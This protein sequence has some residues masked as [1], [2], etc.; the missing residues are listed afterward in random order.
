MRW[1]KQTNF[2]FARKLK[3]P[4]LK[5]AFQLLFDGDEVPL[6]IITLP[7]A[8]NDKLGVG[9]PV[10]GSLNFARKIEERYLGLGGKICYNSAVDEIVT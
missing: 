5:E 1:Q 8:F 3:N 6:L 9:Y 4:F 10:G 2:T 7:L